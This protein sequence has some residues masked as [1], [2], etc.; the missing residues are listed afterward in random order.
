MEDQAVNFSL[1]PNKTPVYS[2]DTYLIGSNEHMVTFNFAQVVPGNNQ[3]NIISRVSLTRTQ[4]K[5]FVKNL[6][7]HIDKFEV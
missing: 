3:Q 6:S 4:A 5:E 2:V 1:D 7:D